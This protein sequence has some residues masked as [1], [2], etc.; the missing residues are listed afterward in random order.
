MLVAYSRQ[1]ACFLST[2]TPFSLRMRHPGRSDPVHTLPKCT[3][4]LLFITINPARSRSGQIPRVRVPSG[5]LLIECF[6][7]VLVD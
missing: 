3:F 2:K 6:T 5:F 7:N 4:P 1:V